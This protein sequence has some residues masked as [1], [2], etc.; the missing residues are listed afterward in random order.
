VVIDFVVVMGLEYCAARIARECMQMT[1]K[2]PGDMFHAA[3]SAQL[4]G[5]KKEGI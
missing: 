3:T 5:A 4:H 1:T 2:Y